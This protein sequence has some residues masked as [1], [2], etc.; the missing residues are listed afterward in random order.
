MR[1]NKLMEFQG[2]YADI[3]DTFDEIIGG[4]MTDLFGAIDPMI[5]LDI[6]YDAVQDF[7]DAAEVANGMQNGKATAPLGIP[8][9]IR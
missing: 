3:E 4:F 9:E 7:Q 1:A 5:D 2:N 8:S 6:H